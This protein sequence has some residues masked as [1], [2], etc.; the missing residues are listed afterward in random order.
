MMRTANPALNDKSFSDVIPSRD[1]TEVMTIDGTV[2]KTAVLLIIAFATAVV[3][4]KSY[5]D[6]D[7]SAAQGFMIIGAL[8]G[9]VLSLI[10]IFKQSA[11]PITAPIYAAFEGLFIGGIS[12]TFEAQYPGIVIQAIS[13]TFG[14]AFALLMVYKSKLIS[15]TDNFRMG[16]LAATGGIAIIYLLSFILSFFGISM[17][18]IHESTGLGI[19]F[20]LIVVTIAALNLVLDFDFIEKAS[21][22]GKAPKYMEWY[23]AFGLLVTLVWLYIEILRLLAK[24]KDRR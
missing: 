4:W 23:G 19:L 13:L 11:S 17:P 20:S 16:L 14:V 18:L 1:G 7:L 12:A 5:F 22:S 8:G 24:M 6:G 21:E 15:V 10:T 3:S 2:N 9:F